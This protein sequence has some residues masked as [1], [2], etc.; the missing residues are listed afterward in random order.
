MSNPQEAPGEKPSPLDTELEALR[1]RV[2]EALE[3]LKVEVPEKVEG[4]A[5]KI[6]AADNTA[7]CKVADFSNGH[8]LLRSDYF[9]IV[10]IQVFESCIFLFVGPCNESRAG[11]GVYFV[12]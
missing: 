4:N 12:F 11:Y 9:R 2:Q 5:D 7:E 10:Q 8:L 6:A 3:E 1:R